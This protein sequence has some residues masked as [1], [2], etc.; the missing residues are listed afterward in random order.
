MRLAVSSDVE[1]VTG[2]YFDKMQQAK[3][4]LVSYDE[5]LAVRLWQVSEEMTGLGFSGGPEKSNG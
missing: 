5:D 1:G 4:A 2:K 3:S